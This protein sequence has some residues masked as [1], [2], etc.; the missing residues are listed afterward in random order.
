MPHIHQLAPHAEDIPLVDRVTRL[1]RPVGRQIDRRAFVPRGE[2]PVADGVL[3]G[4]AGRRE[5]GWA[6]EVRPD[7]VVEPH[8]SGGVGFRRNGGGVAEGGGH[9]G[10]E[11]IGARGGDE[12]AKGDHPAVLMHGGDVVGAVSEF[13][14]ARVV[15]GEEGGGQSLDGM[16]LDECPS[17]LG[18]LRGCMAAVCMGW[19]VE[20]E[21]E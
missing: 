20:E 2:E 4:R 12:A 18:T 7:G 8:P 3:G 14:T 11:A 15:L 19:R 21:E 1:V 9:V 13:E 10:D 6:R 17:G 5:G 16:G